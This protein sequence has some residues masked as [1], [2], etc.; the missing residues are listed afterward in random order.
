M[1]RKI[2][3]LSTRVAPRK[4]AMTAGAASRRAFPAWIDANEHGVAFAATVTPRI[5]DGLVLRAVATKKIAGPKNS[6]DAPRR[7]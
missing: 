6:S 4:S 7:R 1:R 2:K 3:T 5:R